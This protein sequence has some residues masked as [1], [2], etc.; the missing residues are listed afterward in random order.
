ME[1]N[2][3]SLIPNRI[4][5]GGVDG[6]QHL[7]ENEKI[8]IIFDL[9]AEKKDHPAEELSVHQPIMDDAPHQDASIKKA[10]DEVT[11]AYHEG[12]NVYFHCGTG[13]GRAGTIAVATLMELGL[14]DNVDEAENKVK[15]IR[16]KI[17]V[18]PDQKA[19]L[20]RIYSN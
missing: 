15:I 17:N 1:K 11:K 7:L 6:V 5:V 18:K 13:R 3:E 14:A 20:E 2:Y 16:S 8:D 19:A 10:V 4:F 12:K 9:R